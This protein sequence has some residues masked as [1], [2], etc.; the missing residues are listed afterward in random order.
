MLHD[1]CINI[2]NKLLL[3]GAHE[4]DRCEQLNQIGICMGIYARYDQDSEF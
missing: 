1:Q 3:S 4:Y 2:Y